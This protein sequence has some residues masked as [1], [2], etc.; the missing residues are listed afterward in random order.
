MDR[1]WLEKNPR[2][3]GP[4]TATVNRYA[5]GEMFVSGVPAIVPFELKLSPA[6]GVPALTAHLYGAVPPVAVN[7]LEYGTPPMASG[8][9][10][11]VT[12]GKLPFPASRICKLE[13]LG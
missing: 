9:L 11:V 12:L 13:G 8:K 5:P 2:P 1:F 4:L 7:V 3:S 6:G 10:T